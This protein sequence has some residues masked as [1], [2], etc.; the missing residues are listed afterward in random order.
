MLCSSFCIFRCCTGD[1][2]S[3]AY[4]CLDAHKHTACIPGMQGSSAYQALQQSLYEECQRRLQRD[5]QLEDLR[6]QL[7]S[8][9]KQASCWE[10]AAE[11]G[12]AKIAHLQDDI[13]KEKRYCP[14]SVCHPTIAAYTLLRSYCS[15]QMHLQ[16]RSSLQDWCSR[17]IGHNHA[18]AYIT[19]PAAVAKQ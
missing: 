1:H 4:C 17:P 8:F 11:S 13:D 18:Q 6:K 3:A 7:T 19:Y 9:Q 16:D 12:A 10:R 2:A 14:I 5:A 15:A